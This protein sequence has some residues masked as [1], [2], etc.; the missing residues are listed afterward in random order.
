[1][2]RITRVRLL[3]VLRA[4]IRIAYGSGQLWRPMMQLR[5]LRFRCQCPVLFETNGRVTEGE[6]TNLSL[7]GCAIRTP[8]SFIPGDYV[9]LHVFLPDEGL[10]VETGKVRWCEP[11]QFGVQFLKL[12]ANQQGLVARIIRQRLRE[13]SP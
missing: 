6:V 7:F 9:R 10:R 4:T 12:G 1:M 5:H 11:N 3:V 8:R 2:L 13:I